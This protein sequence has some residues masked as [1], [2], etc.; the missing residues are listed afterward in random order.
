MEKGNLEVMKLRP[1]SKILN[2][3][4]EE[5]SRLL[6]HTVLKR[7]LTGMLLYLVQQGADIRSRNHLGS[8]VMNKIW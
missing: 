4:T 1:G 3:C 5:E 2:Y 6:F 7:R 8:G